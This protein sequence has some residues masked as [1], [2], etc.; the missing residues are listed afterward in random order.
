MF[1]GH[2]LTKCPP[3]PELFNGVELGGIWWEE[4][5]LAASIL[6]N[7]KQPPFGMEGSII[8]YDYGSLVKG[9]QKLMR[10]PE[11]KKAAI[12]RSTILKWC[13]DLVSYF[14]GNNATTLIFS[15]TD[16]PKYLLAP[17]RISVFPIQVCIYAASIHICGLF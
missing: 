5:K 11:F 10:K 6:C 8:H 12:H 9:R 3:S 17:R 7:R 4:Q 14:S 2:F 1:G 16:S 15:A 13:K